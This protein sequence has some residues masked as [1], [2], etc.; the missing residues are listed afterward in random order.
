MCIRD[1]GAQKP[2]RRGE[3]RQRSRGAL[4][5]GGGRMVA[6]RRHVH[7]FVCPPRV[8]FRYQPLRQSP[9]LE[10]F[11]RHITQAE[12]QPGGEGRGVQSC[13]GTTIT[14]WGGNEIR[15]QQM[16][17]NLRYWDLVLGH[18]Q[19]RN[20]IRELHR[21]RGMTPPPSDPALSLNFFFPVE[22]VGSMKRP[23]RHSTVMGLWR[24]GWSTW[25]T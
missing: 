17:F 22:S 12:L 9:E 7:L 18:F 5:D 20:C 10:H 23:L 16:L 15:T 24:L 8:T 13:E 6:P 2:D 14:S 21:T 11:K 1:R 25:Q 19:P 4:M 3:G